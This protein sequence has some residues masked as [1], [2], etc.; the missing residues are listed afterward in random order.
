M[1]IRSGAELITKA[2]GADDALAKVAV[3]E[4]AIVPTETIPDAK[5]FSVTRCLLCDAYGQAEGGT[6]PPIA[7]KARCHLSDL[8]AAAK[9]LAEKARKWDEAPT[10]KETAG[11]GRC[12]WKDCDR[13][14]QSEGTATFWL[15]S[16]CNLHKEDSKDI[17]RV[18]AAWKE[19][20]KS[21][22]ELLETIESYQNLMMPILEKENA[23]LREALEPFARYGERFS[24]GA[25]S[26]ISD[27]APVVYSPDCRG[28][29]FPTIG[30][31]RKAQAI[32]AGEG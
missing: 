16:F 13:E 23:R 25:L 1:P 29:G 3:L 7:H 19:C 12:A 18:K 5:P 27:T 2:E 4:A 30:D 22:R 10:Y 21:G 8:P 9:E 14:A 11:T 15:S 17:R 32:L 6:P 31:M 28:S 20:K 26:L 24:I